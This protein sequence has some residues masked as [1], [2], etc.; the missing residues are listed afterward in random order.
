MFLAMDGRYHYLEREMK[1]LLTAL[2]LFVSL[3][4]FAGIQ[5]DQTRV[6]YNGG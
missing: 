3:D 4:T 2:L 5:V 6:I 1:K